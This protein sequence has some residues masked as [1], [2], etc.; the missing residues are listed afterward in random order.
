MPW[1]S[2]FR[3]FISLVLAVLVLTA[4]VGVSVQRHTCRMSG[5]SQVALSVAGP[6]VPGGCIGLQAPARPVAKDNCCD[7]SSHLHKLSTPA[8]ELV[9]KVVVPAP[10]LA[11]LAPTPTW[12]MPLLVA[13]PAT[14]EARWIAADSSP[15]P[16]AGRALLAFVCT[17]VV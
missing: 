9:A 15:P 1:P 2:L 3:R 17:L 6:T 14:S 13:V 7:V 12:P 4:S 11:V 8:H 10:L 5:R 16:R